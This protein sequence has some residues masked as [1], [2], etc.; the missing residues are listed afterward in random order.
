MYYNWVKVAFVISIILIILGGDTLHKD[1]RIIQEE[2]MKKQLFSGSS[3]H[4]RKIAMM[5]AAITLVFAML[6]CNI[7]MSDTANDSTVQTQAALGVQQTML[8][9]QSG[10]IEATVAAQQALLNNQATAAAAQIQQPLTPTPDYNATQIA[11]SVAQT[12]QAQPTSPV[13]AQSPAAPTT[14][15]QVEPTA[16][17]PPPS[18]NLQEWMKSATILVYED[19]VVDPGETQYIKKTLDMMG[20]NYKWDGNAVGRLKSDLLS[21]A[22]GGQPWDL[23]IFGIEARGNVSGEY[24]EYLMD[25]INQGTAVI[26][27]AWHLDAISQGTVS[28]ILAKCGA[29]VIDYPTE[30]GTLIDVL[31]WPISGVSHPVLNTPNSGMSFTKAR[32]TWLWSGDLGSRIEPTGHGDIQLLMGTDATSKD[33]HGVLGVCM[34]GQLILQTFSSHSFGYQTMGP[35]WENYIYNALKWRFEHQ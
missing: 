30:T 6:S 8:A 16:P 19:I 5:T 29:D 23:V 13:M 2:K 4:L 20:L 10:G 12:A 3:S 35:Q 15:P 33:R 31:I 21:G 27:E 22:Q 11:L 14:P 26:L 7:S 32:D 34:D 17:P 25:V 9:M 18:G 28:M 24:F 1:P